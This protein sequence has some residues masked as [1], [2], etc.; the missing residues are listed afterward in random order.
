MKDCHTFRRRQKRDPGLQLSQ[1]KKSICDRKEKCDTNV[2]N[3][4][5][6]ENKQKK[7]WHCQR[8]ASIYLLAI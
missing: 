1:R 3:R 4:N 6:E 2:K 5:V 8:Q 7:Y